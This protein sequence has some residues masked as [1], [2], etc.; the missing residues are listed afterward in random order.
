MQYSGAQVAWSWLSVL[1][2]VSLI[3]CVSTAGPDADPEGDLAAP[4]SV[5]ASAELTHI[6]FGS[7]LHQGF[8]QPILETVSEEAFQLFLFLG[9]NVYGDVDRDQLDDLNPL[10]QAYAQQGQSAE[11]SAL[12]QSTPV[13]AVWDDHDYGLNDAGADF[14]SR[15]GAEQLFEEFWEIPSAA[16]SAQRPGVYDSAILGPEG[17]RVQIILLDT[18]FFRS[19]LRRAD[20]RGPGRERYVPDEDPAKTM[21]GDAQWAW[22]RQQLRQPAEVRLLV[23]S[24]Q[25]LAEGHGWEAW[26]TLPTERQRLYTVLQESGAGGVILLSGDRHRAGI[27]RHDEAINYSLYEIT[28]S[29]LN[30]VV[31][32]IE[33]EPGPQRL[34]PTYLAENY[35]AIAIDWSAGTVQLEVRDLEGDTVLAETLALADLEPRQ[36]DR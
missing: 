31:D 12:R 1:C 13:M 32:D 2:L 7:C 17:R 3:G 28:S 11:L 30:L 10:R 25:V 33:E 9:D 15:E 19:P 20:P 16:A 18:R 21:L 27:Y 29:A 8:P 5:D 4:P 24:I 34:G 26:R 23:S 22:L 35:G 6:G 36:G 14:P